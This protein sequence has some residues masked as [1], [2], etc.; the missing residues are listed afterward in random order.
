MRGGAD[1]RRAGLGGVST[2]R[3]GAPRSMSGCEALRDVAE[4]CV[5]GCWAEGWWRGSRSGTPLNGSRF[6]RR[7]VVGKTLRYKANHKARVAA[8]LR[9]RQRGRVQLVVSQRS[10]YSVLLCC[11]SIDL[12]CL[13]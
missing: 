2:K 11:L 5:G 12:R 13:T 6:T 10:Y 9:G 8:D 4:G 7:A 1:G 3:S